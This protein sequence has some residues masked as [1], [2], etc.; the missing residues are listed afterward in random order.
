MISVV[1]MVP[2]LIFLFM[3]G[4][5]LGIDFTGGSMFELAFKSPPKISELRT[6][7]AKIDKE[8]FSDAQVSELKDASG[9]TITTIRSKPVDNKEQVKIFKD[10]KS[11]FGECGI[12]AKVCPP[13]CIWIV[14][15]TDDAGKPI[16]K[17]DEFFI[18]TSV[19]IRPVLICTEI[20]ETIPPPLRFSQ[21]AD[22]T[23]DAQTHFFGYSLA[24]LSDLAQAY[25][26]DL[27]R[28]DFN[29]AFLLA[30][31][32]NHFWPNL[33]AEAA[34]VNYRQNPRPKYNADMEELLALPPDLAQ[35]FI[36]RHFARFQ[37]QYLLSGP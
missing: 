27:L 34:Y 9:K 28:L 23:P 21:A 29:N 10:F 7:L 17:P 8:T 16:P 6:E 36:H 32:Y 11:K 35:T 18:D 15:Q 3:G 37:G 13:Q 31:E 19:C 2:G 14:Q 26:Y 4:L 24:L 30:R 33:S 5:K 22:A 20:N 12:C 25:N 1:V